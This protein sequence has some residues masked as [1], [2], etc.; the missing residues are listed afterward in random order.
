MIDEKH[1]IGSATIEQVNVL[2]DMLVEMG[3][4]MSVKTAGLI[5][6]HLNKSPKGDRYLRAKLTDLSNRIID[7]L[8]N[9][10]FLTIT[11]NKAKYYNPSKPIFG[12]DMIEKYPGISEDI[13]EATNCF[14]FDRY[15]ACV[16]HLMR[17]MESA[18]QK[19]GEKIGIPITLTY[20]MQWQS[21][22]NEIR[23]ELNKLFPKHGNKE[24]IKFESILGYLE[25]VKI[26]W[27]NPTMHPK[28][29]YAEEEAKSLM[30]TVGI[31]LKE[32]AKV[33]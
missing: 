7:E 20:D 8:G 22:I 3:L 23:R 9:Q 12:K 33:L 26:A 21:I 32:L 14:A 27:R 31:F 13:N 17:V 28:S 25:T 1:D 18:V 6:S 10:L 11:P 15:T 19:L 24:R 4:N 5:K 2:Y 16:F 30:D 29:T